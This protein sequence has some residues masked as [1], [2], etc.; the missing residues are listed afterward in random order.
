MKA[1]PLAP[2]LLARLGYAVFEDAGG[3]ALSPV[4][5]LPDWFARAFGPGAL[6]E[7]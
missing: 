1:A 5:E 7:G 3:G 6:T 4:G 2:T